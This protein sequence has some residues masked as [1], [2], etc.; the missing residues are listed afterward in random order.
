MAD[1]FF[2]NVMPDFV[3]EEAEAEAEAAS[4]QQ[5]Q[6]EGTSVGDSLMHLL[7]MPYSSL[8]QRFQRAALD[9]KE[10]V[11]SLSSFYLFSRVLFFYGILG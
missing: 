11:P 4:T 3:K 9:L 2:P 8:S 5:P 6:E 10:T 7:S 1:R